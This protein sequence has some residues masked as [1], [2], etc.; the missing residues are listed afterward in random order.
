MFTNAFL[1]GYAAAKETEPKKCPYPE[2][3]QEAKDYWRG[4]DESSFL[5]KLK[6]TT[7]PAR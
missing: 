7:T 6:Q 4:Y 1:L 2:N 3:S 5:I